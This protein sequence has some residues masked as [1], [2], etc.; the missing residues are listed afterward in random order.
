MNSIVY[1]LNSLNPREKR[2]AKEHMAIDELC[3]N[4]DFIEYKVTEREELLRGSPPK[5]YQ[6]QY[7]VQ[8]IIGVDENKNPILGYEHTV[9]VRLPK[10]YPVEPVACYA[11]TNVW[12]PN[13]KW[14]GN[15]KGRICGNLKDFG[16][17]YSLDLL[18]LRI[19]QILQYKN[20]LADNVPPYPEEEKVAA[21]VRDYAEP[22]EIVDTF[23]GINIDKIP[24][25]PVEQSIVQESIEEKE[26]VSSVE[27]VLPPPSIKKP[28]ISIIR[29]TSLKPST[30]KPQEPPPKTI[31]TFS[32]I[33]IKK[34]N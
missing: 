7:K 27:D 30:N 12:H 4:N 9:E 26:E 22:L 25:G 21:W 15:Y 2:L 20:Y 5:A 23:N 14:D 6:I 18:I 31:N 11:V 13:I 10:H 28:G 1:D 8:S 3:N 16:K 32:K 29:K 17:T 33:S 34:K 24:E 19:G